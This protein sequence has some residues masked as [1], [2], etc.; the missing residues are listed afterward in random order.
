MQ[1]NLWVQINFGL[2][3]NFGL[4]YNRWASAETKVQTEQSEEKEIIFYFGLSL[5]LIQI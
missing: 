1:I 3:L 5:V 2:S 4:S